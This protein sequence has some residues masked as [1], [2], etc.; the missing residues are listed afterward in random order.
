MR[1]VNGQS[2]ALRNIAATF[3]RPLGLALAATGPACSGE[4]TAPGDPTLE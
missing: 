2:S 1:V 3:V 4:K